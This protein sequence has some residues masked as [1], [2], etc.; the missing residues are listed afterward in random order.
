MKPNEL[1]SHKH[2]VNS[3]NIVLLEHPRVPSADHFNDIANTPLW[4]C[5]MTG[6][7]ASALVN[8]GHNVRIM[9]AAEVSFEKTAEMLMEAAPDILAVHAVYFWENTG[10]LFDMLGEL[11]RKAY[12]GTICLFGFF[13]TLVWQDILQEVEAVDCVVVGEPEDVLVELAAGIASSGEPQPSPGLAVRRQ[14]RPVLAC[15]HESIAPLDRLPFP[16]RPNLE[17]DQTISILASRGCYNGCSFCLVPTIDGG[18][19]VWRGRSVASITAE[20]NDLVMR[21]KNDFY[22][23]DPNFVG[24]GE[25]G[26]TSAITLADALSELCIT[27]GLETR[28]N[29]VTKP[30]LRSLRN[31]GLTSMLLGIESA[32][33]QVLHRLFKRTN[34]DENERAIVEVRD[35]GID[36]EIGFIMFDPMSTIEDIQKN[37]DFLERNRL[38]SRLGRTVNLLCHEQIAFKGTP[39][40]RIAEKQGTM[41]AEGLFG[42]E[43]RLRYEDWRVGWLAG[44]MKLICG[45]ILTQMGKQDSQIHWRIESSGAGPFQ[46]VNDNLVDSFRKLHDTAAHLA[47]QPEEAWTRSQLA[48]ALNKIYKA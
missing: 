21:G 46:T 36:P 15:L 41:A 3:S 7:A 1:R 47:S 18:R 22:F 33:Q 8:S 32:S 23:V 17:N 27:F 10:K 13:P 14:G 24:P 20:I 12:R 42:F 31:A 9:D 34:V 40:Y 48:G 39:G 5:L 11:R 45:R 19:P 2:M 26:Q 38:L 37:L 4:S 6:Y 25:M 29:D 35:A 44:M 43:G 28:A 30:L 16:A